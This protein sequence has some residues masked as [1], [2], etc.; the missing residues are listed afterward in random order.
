MLL[1]EK[2]ITIN[3]PK[4]NIK[5][6]MK[7]SENEQRLRDLL[8]K[9]TEGRLT[10]I[11]TEELNKVAQN[12]PASLQKI[13]DLLSAL[14]MLQAQEYEDLLTGLD[15]NRDTISPSEREQLRELLNKNK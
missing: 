15:L 7:K 8:Q 11:E 2:I 3:H 4:M 10:P 9:L 6:A 14:D 12:D 1:S 13:E 5:T